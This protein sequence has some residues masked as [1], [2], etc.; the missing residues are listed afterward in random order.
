[1]STGLSDVSFGLWREG[2]QERCVLPLD[3]LLKGDEQ[4]ALA[5]EIIPLDDDSDPAF[6]PPPARRARPRTS[7]DATPSE[8]ALRTTLRMVIESIVE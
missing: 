1:M 6:A 7:N 4:P 8:T 5:S 2:I 3:V